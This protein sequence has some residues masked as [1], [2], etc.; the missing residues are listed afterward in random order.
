MLDTRYW[1]F[2]IAQIVKSKNIPAKDGI[3][4]QYP[5]ASIQDQQALAMVFVATA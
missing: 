1:M 4:D 2:R 3:F 5:E